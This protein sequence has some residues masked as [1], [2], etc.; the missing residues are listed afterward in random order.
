MEVLKKKSLMRL[1]KSIKIW[2]V[3]EQ[4][5]A[6]VAVVFLEFVSNC[7]AISEQHWTIVFDCGKKKAFEFYYKLKIVSDV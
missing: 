3:K 7:L 5:K 4:N 6:I 1:A 2:E